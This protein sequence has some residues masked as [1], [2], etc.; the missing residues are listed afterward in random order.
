[1]TTKMQIK[2]G[3][4]LLLFSLTLFSFATARQ[5]KSPANAGPSS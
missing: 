1:M 4:D 5:M 3:A 2:I